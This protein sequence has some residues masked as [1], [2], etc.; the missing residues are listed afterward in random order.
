[1]IIETVLAGLSWSY[2][3]TERG[4]RKDAVNELQWRRDQSAAMAAFAAN[5][6]NPYDERIAARN[7]VR[8]NRIRGAYLRV[9]NLVLG[10]Y[11]L[12]SY[13]GGLGLDLTKNILGVSKSD[14]DAWNDKTFDRGFKAARMAAFAGIAAGVLSSPLPAGIAAS[15]LTGE[16]MAGIYK[17]I[18]GREK[19]K[20]DT[21]RKGFLSGTWQAFTGRVDGPMPTVPKIGPRPLPVPLQVTAGQKQLDPAVIQQVADQMNQ[22]MLLPTP[23]DQAQQNVIPNGKPKGKPSG[24]DPKGG[25]PGFKT[26]VSPAPQPVV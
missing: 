14:N 15:M 20:A 6:G 2:F 21:E 24:G 18:T 12:Y 5:E 19:P 7:V 22:Q 4:R 25:K 1:M 10:Y 13:I 8:G 3:L 17:S 26:P 9:S 23:V 11:G 16:V